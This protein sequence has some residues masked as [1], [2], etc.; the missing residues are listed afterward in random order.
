MLHMRPRDAQGRWRT[1]IIWI[2][3]FSWQSGRRLQTKSNKLYGMAWSGLVTLVSFKRIKG[4]TFPTFFAAGHMAPGV[5]AMAVL[6]ILCL[7]RIAVLLGDLRLMTW[8]RIAPREMGHASSPER[9]R[10]TKLIGK[11]R[12]DPTT[13]AWN[14]GLSLDSRAVCIS[15]CPPKNKAS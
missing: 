7:Q 13:Q 12:W 3:R 5:L 4:S 8:D 10:W 15:T 11:L 6:C 9:S 1:R 14:L 2:L